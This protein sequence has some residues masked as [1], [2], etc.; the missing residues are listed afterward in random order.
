MTYIYLLENLDINLIALAASIITVLGLTI[1]GSPIV[2]PKNGGPI[3]AF[4]VGMGVMVTLFT[5]FGTIFYSNF[6]LLALILC[7]LALLAGVLTYRRGQLGPHLSLALFAMVAVGVLAII[8]SGRIASEWDEFSHWLHAFRYLFENSRFP[9]P[10][11]AA[12]MQSCC[13]AYPYGWPLLAYLSSMMAGFIESIPAV[14]NILILGLFGGLLAQLAQPE[15]KSPSF[16]VIAIG[17]L[18]ATLLGT[19]FVSKLVFSTYA[20]NITSVMV[21]VAAFLTFSI[22]K[23]LEEKDTTTAAQMFI[24]LALVGTALLSV[25]PGNLV[26]YAAILGSGSL[27]ILRSGAWRGLRWP[28]ILVI[29]IPCVVYVLWRDFVGD[30]LSGQELVIQKFSDWKISLIPQILSSMLVVAGHKSGYFFLMVVVVVLGVRGFI[31]MQSDI[32][33]LAVIVGLL[34]IGYNLFL[35]FTYVA[36]FGKNDALRVASYWRY[37]THLGL[38]GTLVAFLLLREIWDRFIA[39]RPLA[40]SKWLMILPIALLVIAPFAFLKSVRFDINPM[41]HFIR[42]TTREI[43]SYV[44]TGSTIGVYDPNGTGLSTVMSLYEWQGQIKYSGQVTA[45]SGS[46]SLDGFLKPNGV[47]YV[48]VM[49]GHHMSELIPDQPAALLL[50]R[51]QNWEAIASFPFPEASFPKKFP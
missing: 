23:A 45:F 10:P 4:A 18:G 2:H 39:Y 46:K 43:P 24:A 35:L 25:K 50:S 48:F 16:P 30:H 33:R 5:V 20:D 8:V 49:S 17:V 31:R 36:V 12:P 9:G 28:A 15:R 38:A 1:L 6:N 14:L 44:P 13:A 42:E 51:A 27:L 37:N 41:K 22:N 19:T 3:V 26:L 34:F 29:L 11:D 7:V 40:H 32:D 21:A 47:E